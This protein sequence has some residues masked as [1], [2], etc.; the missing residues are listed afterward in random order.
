MKNQLNIIP[1]GHQCL[2]IQW[3]NKD[4]QQNIIKTIS[5]LEKKHN[6]K[7]LELVPSYTEL[8]IYLHEGVNQQ[9]LLKTIKN[10]IPISSNKNNEFSGKI[11]EIP[12]C[13]DIDK[14]I[15][16]EELARS[17]NRTP[18]DI[19]ELHSQV[20]YHIHFLG[21]LP[22]FPYLS[23]LDPKLHHPRLESPRTRVTKGSVGIAGN[24]TG[25]YP[26]TSPGGWNIIGQT[27][28]DLFSV[29]EDPPARLKAGNRL[30]FKAIDKGEFEKISAE[31]KNNNYQ[32]RTSND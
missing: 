24:Q 28:V 22:G 17:K 9:D 8:A 10:E 27:P 11:Y 7:I 2:L 20:T 25:I 19:I 13:Y 6:E 12:V 23:G 16:L 1:F 3:K 14:G 26:S 4:P 31:V 5:F 30:R 21:F 29:N 32:I 15:D 18:K